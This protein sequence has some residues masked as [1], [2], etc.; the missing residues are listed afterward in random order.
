MKKDASAVS[1]IGGA[2]GPTSIFLVGR[3][4]MNILQRIKASFFNR[5]YIR[6]RA[7][8]ERTIAS[9]APNAHTIEETI[10]YIRQR[11]HA[12]EADSSYPLYNSRKRSMK[13]QLIQRN[14]PELLGEEKQF[15]PPADLN[16]EQALLAW[17]QKIDAWADECMARADAVPYDVFPTDYHLFIIDRQDEGT[18]EVEIDSMNSSL[19]VSYSG[20]QKIMEPILKDIHLYYGVSEE[21]IAHRSERYLSLLGALTFD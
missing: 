7:R 15:L 12:A 14:Q 1:V 5:K 21:D 9:L 4:E 19:S 18:L 13:H 2:D 16:D 11:Y 20:N 17:Q 8:A 6:K 10:Q 3:K